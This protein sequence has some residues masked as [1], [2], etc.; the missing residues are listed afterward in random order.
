MRARH[1]NRVGGGIAPPI[2]HLVMRGP[3]TAFTHRG[4]SPHQFT[5][6][7][8]AHKIGGANRRPASPFDEGRQFDNASCAPPFL[9]AA[10]ARRWRSAQER[11]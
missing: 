4:L 6:M 1:S 10:V 2:V 3:T 8:G 11:Q 9:S 5:P 7:S